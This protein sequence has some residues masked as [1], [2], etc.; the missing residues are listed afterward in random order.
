MGRDSSSLQKEGSTRGS[1]FRTRPRGRVSSTTRMA[2]NMKEIGWTTNLK[3]WVSW[4]GMTERNISGC[5]CQARSMEKGKCFS[6]MV[7]FIAA[8]LVAIRFTEWDYT[9]GTKR[10]S[11]KGS[12]STTKCLEKANWN[13]VMARTMM[14]SSRVVNT[15]A[16]AQ[17][18][19][20]MALRQVGTGKKVESMGFLIRLIQV[21]STRR[22][23]GTWARGQ[24]PWSN[25]EEEWLGGWRLRMRTV[26]TLNNYDIAL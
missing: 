21:V 12:G 4:A 14:V 5:G 2:P 16:T 18:H 25:S 10:N 17:W 1:W 6:G 9:T 26:P 15:T 23:S 3:A 7:A 8:S 13:G 24:S 19:T 22:W 20:Q 11:M